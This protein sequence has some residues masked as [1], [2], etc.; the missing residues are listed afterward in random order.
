MD[1][2]FKQ[3]VPKIQDREPNATG[4]YIKD[5]RKKVN[6]WVNY[7]GRV[8]GSDDWYEVFIQ[9]TKGD[10]VARYTDIYSD[11]SDAIDKVIVKEK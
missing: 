2:K 8:H 1:N 3:I 10:F 5:K 11:I 6:V 9:T 4:K 7:A